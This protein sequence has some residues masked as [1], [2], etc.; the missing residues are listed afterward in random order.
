MEPNND[1]DN[2][3]G[4]ITLKSKMNDAKEDEDFNFKA[5]DFNEDPF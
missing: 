2:N 5:N 1:F 4:A 3:S